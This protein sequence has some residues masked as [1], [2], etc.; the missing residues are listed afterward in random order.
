MLWQVGV[1]GRVVGSWQTGDWVCVPCIEVGV[2]DVFSLVELTFSAE[3]ADW[4]WLDVVA[5]SDL[6]AVDTRSAVLAM[7][8]LDH[9]ERVI[10]N[11]LI[12]Q[13]DR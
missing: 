12:C 8:M 11:V 1:W 9:T 10:E 13:V 7:D 3:L 5:H 2:L 4:A 6:I